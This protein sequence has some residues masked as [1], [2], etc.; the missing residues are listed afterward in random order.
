MAVRPSLLFKSQGAIPFSIPLAAGQDLDLYAVTA[1][2]SGAAASG[3]FLLC[4]SIFAQSGQLIGRYPAAQAFAIGDSGEVTW[5]PFLGGDAQ[6][7]G[8]RLQVIVLSPADTLGTGDSQGYFL[9]T[10]DMDGMS[11]AACAAGVVTASSS[12]TPTIQLRNLITG[13]DMLSTKI[14]I[15]ANERTSYTAATPPVISA[16]NAQVSTG[17]FV[18]IDVD[19][20]GTGAKGLA[21]GV[22]F[23]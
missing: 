15:D 16:A 11:L 3:R 23:E 2:V 8:V 1:T 17:D 22:A 6:A 10:D 4:L 19:V 14:T 13:N 18:M 21:V 20:A 7:G 9:V 5:S 12:G